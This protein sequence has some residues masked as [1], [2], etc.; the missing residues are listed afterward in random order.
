MLRFT[1][2][3]FI[4]WMFATAGIAQQIHG[5]TDPE[6]KNFNS[7]AH[8]ND[9]SC[10]YKTTIYNPPFKYLLPEAVSETSGLIYHDNAL[11]TINDSGNVP[12]LYK[13]SL[14]TG[15]VLQRIQ[16]ANATNKDWEDLAQD[17][18]YIYIGDFGNNMGKRSKLK[19]LILEKNKIPG[20]GD[21]SLKVQTIEFSF[22][23]FPEKAIKK[24]NNNFDCEA[25][26]SI[27][28]S[29]YIF[30]KNR[31]DH[32]TKLYRLPKTAGVYQVQYVETFDSKGLI[33]GADYH[34]Q[35]KEVVL[36]GYTDKTWQPF[37]WLLFDY[38]ENKLFS[39]NK[40]RIDMLNIPA[41]QTEGIAYINGSNCVIT[42]E[43]HP[44][45]SQTAYDF[46]TEKWIRKGAVSSK[47][48]I[49]KTTQSED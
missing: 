19:I 23:D 48:T 28:D 15:E 6:A 41:T 8:W 32:Q 46:S 49:L 36:V 1:L 9:G 30:T 5:C 16:I 44:L 22:P 10:K 39:G 40:R 37:V 14:E 47:K 26:I 11:W 31:G 4:I 21:T 43:G 38:Q 3:I 25:M 13:L 34:V 24:K 45:F 18:E 20:S 12:V 17:E 29:L 35:S 42:S 33:T 7:S 2:F 27:G